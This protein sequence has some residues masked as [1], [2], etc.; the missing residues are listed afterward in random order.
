[1]TRL[2][3]WTKTATTL[4]L[5]ATTLTGCATAAPMASVREAA[6]PAPR[7]VVVEPTVAAAKVDG[8]DT[9]W[10]S[11]RDQRDARLGIV[12]EPLLACAQ[13]SSAEQSP[14]CV[15]R[16]ESFEVAFGLSTLYRVTHDPTYL[17]AAEASIDA[18]TVARL[19]RQSVYG[20]SYFLALAT[21]REDTKHLTD[22]HASATKVAA[23]L[24]SWLADADDYAFA[25]RTMFGSE[26]N[27]ALVLEHLWNWA[28]L[29]AD[30][31]QRDRLRGLVETRFV[32]KDMDSWCPQTIDG[33]PE[34]FE[35][36]PP[37]LQRASAVLS[38]LP[39]ERSNPWLD[40]FLAAQAELEPISLS[41]LSTHEALNFTRAIALWRVYEATGDTT[42]RTKYVEHVEAGFD[43]M[44]QRTEAGESIDPWHAS[45]AVQALAASDESL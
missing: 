14:E 12:A 7:A 45:F 6:P 43:R 39:A 3:R 33:E 1:M 30:D 8:V 11:F 20:Q 13:A 25:Q 37:C 32:A 42:Y 34:N 36:L 27:A 21:E 38:V 9:A 28:D 10:R 18:K 17:D 41:R 26:E 15:T 5:A 2:N 40:A 31:A 23:S 4:A 24:E 35:F 22:L 19:D 44:A 29:N 16:R